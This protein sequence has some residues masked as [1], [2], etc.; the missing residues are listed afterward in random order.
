MPWSGTPGMAAPGKPWT[1]PDADL[2]HSWTLSASAS[3]SSSGR[4]TQSKSAAS[5]QNSTPSQNRL[6]LQIAS[7]RMCVTF[8]CAS[9]QA[10]TVQILPSSSAGAA[11]ALQPPVWSQTSSPSQNTPLAHSPWFGV[12]RMTSLTSSQLSSVQKTPSST[13]TGV[14]ALQP[15]GTAGSQIS[16]PSQNWLFEHSPLS[17]V[18]TTASATSSQV[19]TVQSTPSPSD[20]GMATQPD[21]GSA[22]ALV[23]SQ[24]SIPVQ[25]WPS[26]QA[27]SSG[28]C[29]IVAVAS[30]QAS[31]VQL[32]PSSKPAGFAG[33]GMVQPTDGWQIST[34]LQKVESLQ[35]TSLGMLSTL[36]VA[37]LHESAVHGMPSSN[38]IGMP[39]MQPDAS[40][41]D[42]THCS[43]PSQ[44][45]PLSQTVWS[46]MFST[47]FVT[48][49]H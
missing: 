40:P 30:S 34:P 14:P 1:V 6:L 15:P 33:T 21:A 42:F 31:S 29:E 5:E 19:S 22:L 17:G 9:S 32:L 47:V 16:S 46:W 43:A 12:L 23:G 3:K 8:F 27:L 45:S 18:L 28:V 48:S 11:D 7:L 4:V 24:L 37:S 38:A 35:I 25:N 39:G 10:S 41:P 13:I 44:Y 36:S 20:G 26:S 49:L 2:L